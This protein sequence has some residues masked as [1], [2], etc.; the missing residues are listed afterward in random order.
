MPGKVLAVKSSIGVNVLNW[1]EKGEIISVITCSNADGSALPPYCIFKSVNKKA[2]F[3]NGMPTGSFVAIH[4]ASAYVT[5][6]L[7]T[8]LKLIL[9]LDS[10]A[11]H[12][13]YY[14]MLELA[15]ENDTVVCLPSHS[16]H[17]LKP[18]DR[19]FS[20]PLKSYIYQVYQNWVLGNEKRIYWFA[21][22]RGSLRC[23]FARSNH[24]NCNRW[25]S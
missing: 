5:S 10:N 24:S 14:L 25:I 8:G 1:V 6:D 18:P 4:M 7:L 3:S 9:S 16:T 23:L 19:S 2:R 11:S 12:M 15:V 20:K 21:V 13:N 22:W 17:Y